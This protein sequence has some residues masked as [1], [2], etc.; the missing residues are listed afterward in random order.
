MCCLVRGV[1]VK[2]RLKVAFFDFSRIIWFQHPTTT[3][4][5]GFSIVMRMNIF[6]EQSR[7][8]MADLYLMLEF[9]EESAYNN[10]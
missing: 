8:Q 1:P 10:K 6:V 3:I 7:F 5:N 9:W 2:I 4:D